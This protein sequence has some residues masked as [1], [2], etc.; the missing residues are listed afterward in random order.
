MKFDIMPQNS[1]IIGKYNNDCFEQDILLCFDKKED[2]KNYFDKIHYKGYISFKSK[3][4]KFDNNNVINFVQNSNIIGKAYKIKELE[5]NQIN[6]TKIINNYNNNIIDTQNNIITTNESR[7][8]I[9]S[10][11]ENKNNFNQ[12][13]KEEYNKIKLPHFKE[14]Q[15]K[16]LISFYFFNEDLKKDIKLSENTTNPLISTSECYIID[17]N[18]MK[19]YKDLFLYEELK[20]YIEKIIKQSKEIKHDKNRIDKIYD[21]LDEE[22]I[23]KIKA[24]Y[25]I[26]NGRDEQLCISLVKHINSFPSFPKETY[27]EVLNKQDIQKYNNFKFNILDNETY[28]LMNKC[29]GKI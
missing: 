25:N 2:M 17:E 4:L 12:Q 18:W 20:E 9:S 19:K 6:N 8:I 26:E 21:L 3:E 15:I 28:E 14:N 10:T 24:I 13:S 22:F 23:N 16:A 29:T 27:F 5:N 7:N 1:I 11:N